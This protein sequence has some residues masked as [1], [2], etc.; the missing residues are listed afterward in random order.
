[1]KK[2]NG[3]KEKQII[4][5]NFEDAEYGFK[6]YKEWYHKKIDTKRKKISEFQKAINSLI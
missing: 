6:N 4:Q 1:M 5:V 3:V 2:E